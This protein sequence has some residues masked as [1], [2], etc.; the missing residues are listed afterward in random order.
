VV[1]VLVDVSMAVVISNMVEKAV[2]TA[3]E[4]AVVVIG[5][6]RVVAAVVVLVSVTVRVVVSVCVPLPLPPCPFLRL[7][8]CCAPANKPIKTELMRRRTST[9]TRR[10]LVRPVRGSWTMSVRRPAG[11]WWGS[12]WS[13]RDRSLSSFPLWRSGA[14]SVAGRSIR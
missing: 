9:S 6:M 1:V 2:D 4:T 10:T 11:G 8:L 12:G 13:G 3:V 5:E 14:A 7:S